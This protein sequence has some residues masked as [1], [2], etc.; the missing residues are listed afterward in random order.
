MSDY[1][2]CGAKK[3]DGGLCRKPAG[4]RTDHV[5]EGKCYYHGGMSLRGKDHPNYK[6]GGYVKGYQ[7]YASA[8][9][10]QKAQEFEDLPLLDLANEL[11][12]QRA[13]IG[14]YLERYQMPGS[15]LTEDSMD[16]I[17]N[18][19]NRIG[20]MVERIVR[21]KNDTSLT[22]AEIGYLKSRVIEVITKYIEDPQQQK[23]FVSELFQLDQPARLE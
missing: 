17:I 10:K 5:G 9:I 23:A 11:N 20:V 4:W 22:A 8:T 21:I 13:L 15:Q 14:E 12:M 6:H 2:K 19:L 1:K 16:L 18:W 7:K 3:R